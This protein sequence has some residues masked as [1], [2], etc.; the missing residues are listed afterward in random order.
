MAG[1]SIV[2]FSDAHSAA[3]L[4]REATVFE[5][6]M[7]YSGLAEALERQRIA[8]TVEFYAEEGKYHYSGHRKCRVSLGPEETL[9]SSGQWPPVRPPVDP[10]G[11]AP[12]A[13]VVRRGRHRPGVGGQ[14]GI[15]TG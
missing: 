14:P 7:S 9:G 10:G 8:Y 15:R 11:A 5:G 13:G 1:K 2:S 12:A 4:G 3:R 6:E